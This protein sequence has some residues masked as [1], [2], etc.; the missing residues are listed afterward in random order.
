MGYYTGITIEVLPST[1]A[2]NTWKSF[3][4][5]TQAWGEALKHC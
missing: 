3:D 4:E 2:L 5:K 1:S